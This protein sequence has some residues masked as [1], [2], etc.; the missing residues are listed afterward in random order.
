MTTKLLFFIADGFQA[1]DLFG[2][3]D[4]FME[5][6]SFVSQA[7]QSKIM[8][9]QAGA[10]S[11][12][13]GQVVMA[14]YALADAPEVD[15]L[16]ICGG[17]GMRTLTLT[18]LQR[19]QLRTLADNA[20]QVLSICTGAFIAARLYP[21]VALTL[22][23]HWRHCQQL[24]QQAAHCRVEEAPLFIQSGPVWSSAGVLSG[25]DLAL[26]II[27]QDHGA[28]VAARV[29]KELVVYLQRR[30][31]Q[32]QYS[33]ALQAQS[34]E[35]LRL[36]PLL[37]WL[38]QN[39]ARPVTVTDMAD[40]AALSSRQLSRLFKLHLH[41]TPKQYLNQLRLNHARDLLCQEN[42]NLEKV[43]GKVGFSSYDSFRRAFYSQF[44][45][46]PSFYQQAK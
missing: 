4:A 26:E 16:I 38:V 14:D 34:G 23:T 42:L 7:Y 10:V 5:T 15:Y 39:L 13:Y 22:T 29:A 36:A 37:E 43:A 21:D 32:A 12:A 44:G 31:G 2:P 33:D 35:S 25:V 20:K 27:R 24:Q 17:T 28:T 30:G 8:A 18:E 45:I 3:L 19:Q 41:T 11:S 46:S 1:L 9:L 40:Y 6:N